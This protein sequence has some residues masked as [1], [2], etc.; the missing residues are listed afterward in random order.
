VFDAVLAVGGVSS[1]NITKQMIHSVR[2]ASAKRVEAAKKKAAEE[3]TAANK[4][5]RICDE[6]TQL[7]SKKARIENCKRGNVNFE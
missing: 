5:K 1:V 7:E 2:N 3:E 4:R 6:I